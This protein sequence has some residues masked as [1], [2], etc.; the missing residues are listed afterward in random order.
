M[1]LMGE[2]V[3]PRS[4]CEGVFETVYAGSASVQKVQNISLGYVRVITLSGQAR[5]S[6]ILIMINGFSPI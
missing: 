2:V 5:F 4:F 1:I 6:P 3:K